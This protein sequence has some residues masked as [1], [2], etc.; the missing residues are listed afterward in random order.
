M[1]LLRVFK[2]TVG[3]AV[4]WGAAW[5]VLSIPTLVFL[6]RSNLPN[7]TM[8]QLVWSW[9]THAWWDAFAQ[10]AILGAGFAML[11]YL[12][13]R[14]MPALRYR[15]LP[16]IGAVG[17][18]ATATIG[19]LTLGQGLGLTGGALLATLGA[20]TAMGSLAL[21]RRAPAAA[22]DAPTERARI[23]AP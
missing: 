13:A 15:S 6:L 20:G 8:S 2:A 22:L 5:S 7:M 1:R 3:T 10:G 4:T 18:M 12:F 21:A 16:V 19:V 9:A 11:L 14:G 17:A 23:A